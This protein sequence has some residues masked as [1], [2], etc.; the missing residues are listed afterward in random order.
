MSAATSLDGVT[1][2]G[3]RAALAGAVLLG[4][5]IAAGVAV[6]MPTGSAAA[7]RGAAAMH[8]PGR[9]PAKSL[10]V[11]PD[12]ASEAPSQRGPTRNRRYCRGGL[13]TDRGLAAVCSLGAPPAK[14]T[15]RIAVVGDSHAAQWRPALDRV[16]RA[17]GWN[18]LSTTASGCDIGGPA[19]SDPACVSWRREVPRWLAR[20]PEIGTV[21]FGQVAKRD[22]AAPGR[23]RRA[24][25]D[26][27]PSVTRILTFRDTP[28]A[29]KEVRACVSRAL[30]RGKAP[31]PACASR[32]SE[33]L[34]RDGAAAAARAVGA[35]RAGVI[36]MSRYFCNSRECLPVIGGILVYADGSHQTPQ[37]NLTLAPYLGAELDRLLGS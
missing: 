8:E 17:R 14:A 1:T 30:S 7:C 33:A 9:C 5:A 32:R 4:G 25:A 20:H 34:R 21:I 6:A 13:R 26:L 36:D 27:P 24:W 2:K 28:A 3:K 15:R 35:P 31:G 22:D 29:R 11:T 12:P 37:F 23:Y 16:G 18:F 19:S 10:K